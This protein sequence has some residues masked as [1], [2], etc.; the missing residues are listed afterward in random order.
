[1][2]D[3]NEVW[4]QYEETKQALIKGGA[5]FGET[6]GNVVRMT[7]KKGQIIDYDENDEPIYAPSTAAPGDVDSQLNS[8]YQQAKAKE[9]EAERFRVQYGLSKTKGPFEAGA[10]Y[11]D[12]EKDKAAEVK[13]QFADFM[14][15]AKA[16][17]DLED[18]EAK[19]TNFQN[20][21][22]AADNEDVTKGNLAEGQ[23]LWR[24]NRRP[25]SLSGLV[26]PSL[27]NSP[28]KPIYYNNA[29][30]G[31]PGPQGFSDPDYDSS[32]NYT[33]Y[34]AGTGGLPDPAGNR[35][36]ADLKWMI[37]F[38]DVPQ[39]RKLPAITFPKGGK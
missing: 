24:P 33:G 18:D 39:N 22:N 14:D 19:Y 12:T 3:A 2:A 34:A 28:V 37:G 30:V 6:E 35:I 25:E 11:V 17:Y 10:S 36:P 38:P 9:Q 13:R 31:L 27:P 29:G 1:V 15:R 21:A 7:S 5:A 16:L 4:R 8:L 26:R 32:G 20:R 23:A